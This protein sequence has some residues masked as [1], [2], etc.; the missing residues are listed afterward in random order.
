MSK[1]GQDVFKAIIW[2]V[3]YKRFTS[4]KYGNSWK[5]NFQTLM[6]FSTCTVYLF[7]N[8]LIISKKD[9]HVFI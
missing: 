2:Q 9:F 7:R 1:F 8:F 3:Q 4:L 6:L 5:I